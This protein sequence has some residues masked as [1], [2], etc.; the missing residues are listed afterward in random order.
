MPTYDREKDIQN[1][2]KQDPELTR[3]QAEAQVDRN[4]SINT[5]LSAGVSKGGFNTSLGNLLQAT[6]INS[7]ATTG[8]NA[9]IAREA[10]EG[11]KIGLKINET[12]S[13]FQSLTVTTDEGETV[14][15]E[16]TVAMMTNAVDGGGIKV[17]RTSGSKTDITT[18]TGKATSDGFLTTV[19]TQGSPKGIEQ[20][21]KATVTT[22]KNVLKAKIQESSVNPTV[23]SENVGVD[24]SEN[25]AKQ[26]ATKTKEFNVE[27][28]NPFGSLFGDIGGA[29][30]NPFAN[31]LANLSA[32]ATG[33]IQKGE[34]PN[35]TTFSIP[36]EIKSIV[37]GLPNVNTLPGVSTTF[38]QKL[39]YP[40]DIIKTDGSTNINQIISKNQRTSSEVKPTDVPTETGKTPGGWRGFSTRSADYK[41]VF[42][43]VNGANELESELRK[44]IIT[45]PL[46][47]MVVAS[48]R[49]ATNEKYDAGSD[50]DKWK[51]YNSAKFVYEDW[52]DTYIGARSH[53]FILRDGSIQRG[54]PIGIRLFYKK[55]SASGFNERTIYVKMVGGLNLEKPYD[56]NL[57]L[58]QYVS[59]ESYT[60]AQWKAFEI[61]CKTFRKVV[62][63]GEAI[64]MDEMSPRI[65]SA[66]FNARDWTKSRF[67]WETLYTGD[68][69]LESRVKNKLGP[70]E[71]EEISK[72][73]PAKVA[74]P[75]VTP[76]ETKPT[77]APKPEKVADP[78]TGQEPVKT[79]EE[80][81][82]D[83]ER[84][85]QIE[86]EMD[87]LT[88]QNNRLME[89]KGPLY[90]STTN[91]SKIEAINAK[92]AELDKKYDEL[93]A[94]AQEIE[95][96]LYPGTEYQKEINN[97][98]SELKYWEE[99]LSNAQSETRTAPDP[100]RP[101]S[102]QRKQAAAI[103][104]RPTRIAKAQQEIATLKSKIAA[105]EVKQKEAV[106]HQ[107]SR[108]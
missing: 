17:T 52:W 31:I 64:T 74:K 58:D 35:V 16:P 4:R 82:T 38:N 65:K 51:Y 26:V 22:D 56:T 85:R 92:I 34:S 6:G 47:C 80:A 96:R 62:P 44:A 91:N 45:R 5:S 36:T 107:N 99:Q 43:I 78:Q 66:G 50:Q 61:L 93:E 72:Y 94:E 79:K 67:G 104:S 75:T 39:P 49:T 73:L 2:M 42:T 33:A 53:Y 37:P 69:S 19:I 83:E 13:G 3:A 60:P 87:E 68:N 89:E 84:L 41:Q 18:L 28:G 105:A 24:V 90:G 7:L 57:E 59:D 1:L 70:F 108:R 12:A 97:L 30:G 95:S 103:A 81:L 100:N 71:M 77:P 102:I 20:A 9:K 76:V 88:N 14:T 25:V 8:D 27:L 15:V 86:K 11:S 54:R 40:T 48:S 29:A 23:A 98:K 63:G 106:D 101:A 10:I 55:E 46:T 21:L 32:I